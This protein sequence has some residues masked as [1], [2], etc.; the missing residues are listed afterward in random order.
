MKPRLLLLSFLFITGILSAQDTI[1]VKTGE[2]I[3]A[4]IVEKNSMEIKYKKFGQPEPAAIYSVFISDIKSIHYSDGI[5]ADYMQSDENTGKTKALSSKDMAGTMS[6]MRFSFGFGVESFKRNTDDNLQLFW[7]NINGATGAPITGNPVS[8]P[9]NLKMNSAIGRSGRN[10]I[11]AE[12]QLIFTP[13]DAIYSINSSGSNE[14]MLKNFYY[15]IIAIYGHT[16]NHKKTAVLMLEPG[17]DLGFMSGFIKINNNT[18]DITGNLGVGFHIAT[19]FDY[20]ISRRLLL[21]A[22]IGQ[23]F[24]EIEESHESSTSSTGYSSFYVDP[25]SNMDLLS[26]KWNGTYV[27]LGLSFCLYGKMKTGQPE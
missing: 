21:S 4:V 1:F 10:W 13:E 8:F 20:L 17:L 2:V 24:M 9:I 23:R 18:Y 25:P 16:L 6:V 12:L 19:G 7:Q 22:R 27:S 15:N 26:V 14:L 5:V 11:G 3:P